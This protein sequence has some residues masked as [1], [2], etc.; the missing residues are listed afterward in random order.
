MFRD[1][2]NLLCALV[3]FVLMGFVGFAFSGGL[4]DL[5]HDCS[6]AAAHYTTQQ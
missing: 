3:G 1:R 2:H 4:T 5:E 6:A